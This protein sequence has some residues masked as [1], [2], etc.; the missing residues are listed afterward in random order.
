[1]ELELKTAKESQSKSL[2]Q[3]ENAM[4]EKEKKTS[5]YINQKTENLLQI[6]QMIADFLAKDKIEKA[7]WDIENKRI[8]ESLDSD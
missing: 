8:L 7:A 6:K 5:E 3:Y 2:I 4:R 1:L